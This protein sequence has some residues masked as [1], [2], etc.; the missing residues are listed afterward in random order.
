MNSGFFGSRQY[1]VV[2]RATNRPNVVRRNT[3]IY[4]SHKTYISHS[5]VHDRDNTI[6]LVDTI[7]LKCRTTR[8][9][10]GECDQIMCILFGH[11]ALGDWYAFSHTIH[12]SGGS[13]FIKQSRLSAFRIACI[14]SAIEKQCRRSHRQTSTGLLLIR[15][16]SRAVPFFVAFISAYE[17]LRIELYNTNHTIRSRSQHKT[18]KKKT[19]SSTSRLTAKWF[20]FGELSDAH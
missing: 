13:T 11:N 10:F 3:L 18:T 16:L 15:K 2:R 9:V 20:H 4:H 6:L 8:P 17:C 12:L 5:S 14:T 7:I 19:Q 1:K